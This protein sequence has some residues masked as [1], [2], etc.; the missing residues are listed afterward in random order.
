[1]NIIQK[2]AKNTF[3]LF[4]GQ[5]IVAILSIILSISVARNLGDI[6]FGKYSFALAFVAFFAVF[7]DLGY[8]TL[9]IRNVSRD[10]S[11]ASKYL[12][13]ILSIRAF[14]SLIIFFFIVAIINIMGYPED[15]K[16]VVYIFGFY[17]LLISFSDVFKVTFRAFQ[18][19]EYEA[20]ITIIFNVVRVSLGLLVLFLGYGL[21]ALALVFL[22]SGV[23]D[24]LFSFLI[25]EAKFVKSRT[26]FDFSFLK[27]TITIAV[28]I[29]ALSIFALIYAKI[30]MIMLSIMKGDAVVGWYAAA[31]HLTYGLK[32]IP[33]LFMSALF[34]MMAHYY[35]SS[36]NSLKK[37]YE[38]SFKYLLYLGLPI[39]VGTSLLSE[40]IILFLYGPQ[41]NNSIIAL[42]I[43]SWDILL[44]FL[45]A[46]SAFLL[47]S[48][49]KQNV[50]AIVAGSTAVINVFL[51]LILIPSFSYVGAAVA[52]IV[53]EGFLLISYLLLNSHYLHAIPI[54]KIIGRPI[55]ACGIMGLFLYQTN[56]IH[57]FLQIII[58]VIIYFVVLFFL[59]G[60]S[61]EDISL[62][63]KILNK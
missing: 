41:F 51:N 13:N 14:L 37:A 61:A 12:S 60:F 27:N 23:F 52:T 8:N 32:P 6:T 49:D 11:Q 48:I 57:L 35:V 56:E 31:S 36:K 46:C 16:I 4:V 39:A 29:G 5:S 7:L 1:M 9:L 40:K 17:I 53:A 3:A 59:K 28:P 58:A 33:H 22:F 10:L 34:P 19:M 42:Q 63:K 44:I 62:F 21:I 45:Y 15:T 24:F 47:L 2:I 43:L 55:V 25:C 20:V 38:K 30:D 18:K 26:E 54:H 50:M